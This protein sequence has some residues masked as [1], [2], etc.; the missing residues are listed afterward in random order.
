MS[1][2]K[3][4]S[5]GGGSRTG[6]KVC[7]DPPPVRA[8]GP[9]LLLRSAL[10]LQYGK[11]GKLRKARARLHSLSGRCQKTFMNVLTARTGWAYIPPID[12]VA[13]AAGANNLLGNRA[14]VPDLGRELKLV[15]WRLSSS[16]G[17]SKPGSK[18]SKPGLTTGPNDL[19]SGSSLDGHE[20]AVLRSS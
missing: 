11:A 6:R 10:C 18:K 3:A 17:R 7:G 1:D 4:L 9:S 2:G 20:V 16:D 19:K 13:E 5:T 8:P 12:A 15:L 14:D